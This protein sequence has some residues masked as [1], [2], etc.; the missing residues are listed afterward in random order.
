MHGRT[1][2]YAPGEL[3]SRCVLM[4]LVER[5][6]TLKRMP[7]QKVG[8][9]FSIFFFRKTAGKDRNLILKK[10]VKLRNIYKEKPEKKELSY[11]GY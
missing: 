6:K 8:V 10:V 5:H 7:H 11:N 2:N 9:M 3:G 4:V 1:K